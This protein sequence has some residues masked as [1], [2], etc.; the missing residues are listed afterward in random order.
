MKI[1]LICQEE[2]NPPQSHQV[3]FCGQIAANRLGGERGFA[4]A[5]LEG[6]SVLEA[7][8]PSA[9]GEIHLLFSGL[10]SLDLC[11]GL[12]LA[13]YYLESGR[14][15]KGAHRL[16]A[17]LQQYRAGE[18]LPNLQNVYTL[19]F[20]YELAALRVTGSIS[21]RA[22]QVLATVLPLIKQ[23]LLGFLLRKDY[24]LQTEP[25][26][27]TDTR[28]A[29]AI[30]A[31]LYDYELY[32][33][34]KEA[35]RES[36]TLSLPNEQGLFTANCKLEYYRQPPLCALPR[37][38][39]GLEGSHAVLYAPGNCPGLYT[40]KPLSFLPPAFTAQAL[41]PYFL[42]AE[43]NL[44]GAPWIVESESLLSAPE[45]KFTLHNALDL[46]KSIPKEAVT[47]ML[48]HA[49]VPVAENAEKLAKILK[50]TAGFSPLADGGYAYF[51]ENWP[52]AAILH[53]AKTS[54]GGNF[55][56]APAFW[57]VTYS[58]SLPPATPEKCR[59]LADDF[60]ARMQELLPKLPYAAKENPSF[61][62]GF[63]TETLM[64]SSF[65]P[66]QLVG[67]SLA[68]LLN[69]RQFTALQQSL[70]TCVIRQE[71]LG[72]AEQWRAMLRARWQLIS[73]QEVTLQRLSLKRLRAFS[74]VLAAY[75]P[76]QGEFVELLLQHSGYTASWNS[77]LALQKNQLTLFNVRAVTASLYMFTLLPLLVFLL[78]LGSATG[79]FP[80]FN[81]WLFA[82]VPNL[83]RWL[84]LFLPA[85]G[86]SVL[87]FFLG[88]G[89]QLGR[90]KSPAGKGQHNKIKMAWLLKK[91]KTH[92]SG[93]PEQ[94]D[95][96][97]IDYK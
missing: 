53:V 59:E 21:Q 61:L 28:M 54:A 52:S 56:S 94:S 90:P 2:Q 69:G 40:A 30:D 79:I 55:P 87:F 65:S 33:R 91:V 74:N 88:K 29:G 68:D 63:I 76:P 42:H 38:W 36:V 92:T 17:F 66:S 31:A 12:Y 57:E 7:L 20:S 14:M 93:E 89:M 32:G 60:T 8:A 39:A 80:L 72:F 95:K 19:A 22:E 83:F 4:A 97:E 10:P 45:S 82:G 70:H 47:H 75:R 78:L 48:F 24:N 84:A 51:P 3:R 50:K 25:I 96:I 41:Y 77:L 23:S 26:A 27:L 6:A 44:S 18:V 71:G 73:L 86:L 5:V 13:R 15:P 62:Y 1:L 11:A 35:R 37:L 81:N 64:P 58:S 9:E 67:W 46:L 34:E 43:N 49:A 16:C 85:C